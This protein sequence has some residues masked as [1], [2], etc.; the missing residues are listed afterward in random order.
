GPSAPELR[1]W[2]RER[3]PD[4]MVPSSYTIL[5]AFPLSPNGKIDRAALPSPAPLEASEVGTEYV[6]PRNVPEIL[7]AE[8]T[9]ELLGR[10]HVG[11]FDVFLEIALD[12]ILGI[13]LVPRARA[14]GLALDPTPVSRSPS[15]AGRAAAST[16]VG[17]QRAI[18]RATRMVE[19]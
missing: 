18:E 1:R 11:V 3:V 15:I 17:V 8:L 6:G 4:S 14:R 10:N 7:L 5:E 13:Q 16:N 9:A 19:P 2:L 12:S